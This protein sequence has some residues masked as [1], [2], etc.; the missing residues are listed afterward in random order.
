M[1]S[2]CQCFDQTSSPAFTDSPTPGRSWP[3]QNTVSLAWIPEAPTFI[4]VPVLVSCRPRIHSHNAIAEDL[5][6]STNGGVENPCSSRLPAYLIIPNAI[7]ASPLLT[8]TI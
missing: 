1:A 2:P 5:L 3:F 4:P 7:D 6:R 8:T